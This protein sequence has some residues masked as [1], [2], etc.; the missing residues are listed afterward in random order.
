MV[1][2]V[3]VLTFLQRIFDVEKH[4]A[5][6]KSSLSTSNFTSRTTFFHISLHFT[7][8]RGC[9]E[10]PYKCDFLIFIAIFCL[11]LAVNRNIRVYLVPY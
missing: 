5:R 10:R 11:Y 7:S 2:H 8:F 9:A 6:Q 3:K 1:R 4:V